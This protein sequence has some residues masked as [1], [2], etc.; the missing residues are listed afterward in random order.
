MPKGF[1]LEFDSNPNASFPT[2]RFPPKTGPLP[3]LPGPLTSYAPT[4]VT[5]K[6]I[7]ARTD[8]EHVAVSSDMLEFDISA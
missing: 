8:Y 7:I 1:S 5:D 2:I 6:T 4:M 3:E